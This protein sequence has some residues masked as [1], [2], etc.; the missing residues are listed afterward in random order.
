MIGYLK[1]RLE[2]SLEICYGVALYMA[3]E[4]LRLRAGLHRINKIV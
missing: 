1:V 4:I 2:F 3:E